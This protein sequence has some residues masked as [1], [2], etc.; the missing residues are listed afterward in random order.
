MPRNMS[1]ML[2]TNQIR[3]RTKDVTRRLGWWFLKPGDVLNACEKCQ[4]LKKGEKIKR[5]CQ[6]QVVSTSP[7]PLDSISQTDCNREGFPQLMSFE[8]T[9]MFVREM[10]CSRSEIVNR[11]EFKYI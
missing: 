1:F 11:I 2:T 3:A 8:F 5:I 10:K 6:I 4:G 7:E 9:T